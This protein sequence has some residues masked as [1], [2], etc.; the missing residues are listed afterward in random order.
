MAQ[1]CADPRQLGVPDGARSVHSYSFVYDLRLRD[2]ERALASDRVA[3][4]VQEAVGAD[5]LVSVREPDP[6]DRDP[7][8]VWR[9]V[10]NDAIGAMDDAGAYERWQ[11]ARFAARDLG[12]ELA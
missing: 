10:L 6:N 9:L 3:E 2:P 7:V 12:G 4:A 1:G 8:R 11:R 5:V